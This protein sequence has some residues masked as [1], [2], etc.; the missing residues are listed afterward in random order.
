MNKLKFLL[1]ILLILLLIAV[2]AMADEAENLTGEL[3]VKVVDKPGKTACI[4]D[5]KYTTFWES[6]SRK[7]PWVLITSEKPIYGLYLCFQKMPDSY[8]IQKANGD[9][10]ITVA[11]GG[12]PRYHHVF[13]ELDGLKKI[14]ILSTMNKKNAMGF[15][16]IY[17]FGQGEIPD[18]VQRWEEPAGK[19][20][21]VCSW[22]LRCCWLRL[23]LICDFCQLVCFR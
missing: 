11:E 13:F 3:T 7:D 15:N 19:A 6:S 5:G 23:L 1:P 8:V 9:D 12:E 14:R 2:P 16:E 22:Y 10:W 21:A 17:A 20:G 4:T 18:W